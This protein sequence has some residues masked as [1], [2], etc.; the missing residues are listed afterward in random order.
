M[1]CHPLESGTCGLQLASSNLQCRSTCLVILLNKIS[2]LIDASECWILPLGRLCSP[3]CTP[4]MPL[5]Q[6]ESWSVA[7]DRLDYRHWSGVSLIGCL[8]NS[9]LTRILHTSPA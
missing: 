1:S 2:K 3:P 4:L 8:R 7:D 9:L 6:Q 5:H